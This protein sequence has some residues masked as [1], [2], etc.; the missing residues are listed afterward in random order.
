MSAAVCVCVCVCVPE[1]G[2]TVDFQLHEQAGDIEEAIP[3][4][5]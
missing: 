5:T 3:L 1:V 4:F 2:D